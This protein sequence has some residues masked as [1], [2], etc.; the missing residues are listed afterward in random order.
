MHTGS[1]SVTIIGGT[2]SGN[3][4]IQGGGIYANIGHTMSHHF[5]NVTVTGNT[6]TDTGGGIWCG[7]TLDSLFG[8]VTGNTIGWVIS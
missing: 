6:A 3:E 8:N 5:N 7:F 1:A 4:A 2:F